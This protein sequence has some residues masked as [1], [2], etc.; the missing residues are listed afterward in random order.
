MDALLCSGENVGHIDF[1]N[2][3]NSLGFNT[4]LGTRAF[5]KVVGHL[6][7]GQSQLLQHDVSFGL[8]LVRI[9]AEGIRRSLL[10]A[11]QALATMVDE[12]A[13][14]TFDNPPKLFTP[15]NWQVMTEV[16]R[17]EHADLW[18]DPY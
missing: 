1:T 14:Q 6:L 4:P 16:V 8:T 18:T 2:A 15:Q 11:T 12:H 5:N 9:P 13:A 7:L 3:C 17:D 10:V